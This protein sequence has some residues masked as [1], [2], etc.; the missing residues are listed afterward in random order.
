MK[1]TCL[2]LLAASALPAFAALDIASVDIENVK[3][4]LNN[5]EAAAAVQT[6]CTAKKGRYNKLQKDSRD[7]HICLDSEKNLLFVVLLNNKVVNV[8]H[9]QN[10]TLD[11]QEQDASNK[12]QQTMRDKTINQ[13]GE[14]ALDANK[15]VFIQEDKPI[16]LPQNTLCWGDCEEQSKEPNKKFLM[17]K[18]KALLISFGTIKDKTAVIRIL[19]DATNMPAAQK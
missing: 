14:P 1:K 19:N 8:M 17:T 16:D 12:W 6:Y 3:L 5:D 18:S 11:N 7:T 2:T 13:Y 15:V 9:A 4:G 10:I